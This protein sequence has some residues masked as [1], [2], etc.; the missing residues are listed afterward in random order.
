MFGSTGANAI[1]FAG[2]FLSEKDSVFIAATLKVNT[3][4]STL[5]LT[6]CNIG[7]AACIHLGKAFTM[8]GAITKLKLGYARVRYAAMPS[9]VLTAPCA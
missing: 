5:D 9:A 7:E 6:D 4:M 2:Q 1:S 3:P 8:N